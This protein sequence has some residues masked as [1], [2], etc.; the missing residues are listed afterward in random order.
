MSIQ[1]AIQPSAETPGAVAET[2]ADQYHLARV[3]KVSTTEYVAG[4]YKSINRAYDVV[5]VGGSRAGEQREIKQ[6]VTVSLDNVSA[7]SQ[8][9]IGPGERVVV[10]VVSGG[11]GEENYF[12][13]DRY[14]LPGLAPVLAFFFA[15]VLSL[16]RKKGLGSLLG[17]AFS[18]Y[19]ISAYLVPQILAGSNPLL[20]S[21]LSSLAIAV[22]SLYLAHGFNKRTSVALLGMVITVGLS[23]LFATAGVKW[24]NLFGLGSEDALILQQL[25]AFSGL[26]FSGLLLAGIMIGVLGVLDDTATV[27]SATVE[28]LKRA[29]PELTFSEL[30]RR[31]ISVGREHIS[32]LVNT[33][34]LA[35]AGSQLLLFLFFY[36]DRNTP[37][38]VTLNSEFIAEEMVRTLVG[39]VALVLAVPITT[40]LAAYFFSKEKI[41]RKDSSIHIH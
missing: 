15:L 9:D 34:F 13:A 37:L 3:E 26:D 38:W 2:R 29:N 10:A 23:G 35:Y 25:P 1:T 22:V 18:V 7:V 28:E 24:A 8:S 11:D 40:G 32:S 14:R 31:G 6:D 4:Q 36:S 16:G 33:L 27:Q 5:F 19:V 41:E 17:L 39:S 21:I 20:V 30:Y 12:L